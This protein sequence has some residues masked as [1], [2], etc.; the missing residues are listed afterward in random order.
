MNDLAIGEIVYDQDGRSYELVA[1][2]GGGGQGRIYT[3][4]KSDVLVKVFNLSSAN[5]VES[6]QRVRRMPFAGLSVTPPMSILESRPGYTL[7]FQNDMTVARNLRFAGHRVH[8][9]DFWMDSGGLSRRLS[10]AMR[11]ALVVEQLHARGVVYGDLNNVNVMVSD[12][13]E[14]DAVTIIDLDNAAYSGTPPSGWYTPWFSAPE[15]A[16]GDDTSFASDDFSLAILVFELITMVHPFYSGKRAM[17]APVGG[18]DDRAGQRCLLP[19]SIDPNDDSNRC[20]SYPV[21]TAERLIAEPLMALLRRSLGKGRTNPR[22][23]ATAAELRAATFACFA[24]VVVCEDC[25]WSYGYSLA[26]TCPDC[27]HDSPTVEIRLT[28]PG[29]TEP[30]WRL[31]VG[32]TQR[33]F[34]LSMAFPM[35]A[36]LQRIPGLYRID[37]VAQRTNI[38]ARPHD[39]ARIQV[40]PFV[41]P[42]EILSLEGFGDLN[43]DVG[44][45]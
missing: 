44:V 32:A 41:R 34:D 24:D 10:L 9:K 28:I 6:V 36:R 25:G 16:N 4:T 21:S 42:G 13:S 14:H 30:A 40:S 29:A 12:D 2:I 33:T 35:L 18:A 45:R 15:V 20:D 39:D 5:P 8:P 11:A 31:R 7:K 22:A 27:G 19:S 1:H 38:R 23:R 37:L 17:G 3:T 43:I 26:R